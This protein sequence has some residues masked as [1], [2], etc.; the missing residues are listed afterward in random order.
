MATT[1]QLPSQG[2]MGYAEFN[3]KLIKNKEM[4]QL[5]ISIGNVKNEMEKYYKNIKLLLSGIEGWQSIPL[6]DIYPVLFYSK[7]QNFLKDNMIELVVSCP[8]CGNKFSYNLDLNDGLEWLS[9]SDEISKLKGII[10]G[11]EQFNIIKPTI[12]QFLQVYET[13]LPFSTTFTLK[14]I[15]FLT[16]FNFNINANKIVKAMHDAVREDIILIQDLSDKLVSKPISK[17]K[18]KCTSCGK[19]VVIGELTSI[20]ITNPFY[21]LRKYL[22]FPKERLIY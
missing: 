12:S 2:K 20:L 9:V 14:E 8:F 6:F 11:G 17:E 19:E 22:Q 1:E 4:T 7:A 3:I 21:E 16:Y 15:Y 10:L 5:S 13:L 18:A